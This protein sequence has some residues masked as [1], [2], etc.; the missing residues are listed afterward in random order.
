MAKITRTITNASPTFEARFWSKVDKTDS[1]WLWTAT[2]TPA[3]YGSLLLASGVGWKMDIYAHRASWE[4]HHGRPIPDGFDVDHLCRNTSCVNPDHLEAV[5]HNVN[6]VRGE[7][8]NRLKTH[9]KHGHE[10]TPENTYT[11][12]LKTGRWCRACD[13]HRIRRKS[14]VR[15]VCHPDRPHVARGL[16]SACYQRA[17]KASK[18]ES[19]QL[20]VGYKPTQSSAE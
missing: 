12:P 10:Y 16:C 6:I 14:A 3:G 1:C 17:S 19:P 4:M 11:P 15:A 2:K 5:P 9:C 18:K 8:C 20:Q 7:L 13:R